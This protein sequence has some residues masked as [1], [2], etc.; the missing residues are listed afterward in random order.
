MP[1]LRCRHVDL[2]AADA[3]ANAAHL[4]AEI[5]TAARDR[6]VAYRNGERWIPR[7]QSL[8]FASTQKHDLPFKRGGMYL[9]SGGLGGIGAEI[10][11]YLLQHYQAKLLLVG[12]TPLAGGNSQRRMAYRELQQLPGEVVYEA[13]DVCDL[14]A[15]R[16]AV[17]EAQARWQCSVD[18]VIHL[19]GIYQERL[20]TEEGRDSFEAVLRPKVFGTWALSQ[21]LADAPD[22]LFI[23]FSSVN[24]SFG[25][26]LVGAYSAAN[27]FLDCFTHYQRRKHSVKSYC[28]EWSMWDELG[29]SRGYPMKDL[30][31]RRGYYAISTRQGLYSF[32]AALRHDEPHV[33][34]GL[35]ASSRL[36]RQQTD[37][38]SYGMHRLCAYFTGKAD[39][40]HGERLNE[41]R[42]EDRFGSP[43]ACDFRQVPKFPETAAGDID[44]EKLTSERARPEHSAM[45]P[46]APQTPLEE[47]IA[48]FWREV[49]RLPE[50]GI[51]DNFL[52]LGGN[53]LLATQITSRIQDAFNVRLSLRVMFEDCT[54]SKLAVVVQRLL[55]ERTPEGTDAITQPKSLDAKQALARFEQLS[56]DEV[57]SL[58]NETLAQDEER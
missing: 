58:L 2:P 31:R 10:G 48:G 33:L 19:A 41:L 30:A 7:L 3:R 42:V 12:R 35:D 5:Q 16:R 14:A 11:K 13:V 44:R 26:A 20:L 39:Q 24:S 23:S 43:I 56:D 8:D 18:G 52:E 53:S 57:R 46:M 50:L 45:A 54:V 9:L 36:I 6:E 51:Q 32:L 40:A 38:G 25:G 49:L 28:L 4:L 37:I 34:V 17:A 1:W 27:G 55:A 22:K 47:R 15:L 21:L 29:M